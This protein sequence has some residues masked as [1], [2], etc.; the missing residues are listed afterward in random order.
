MRCAIFYI[1]TPI[2]QRRVSDRRPDDHKDYD[3]V[4]PSNGVDIQDTACIRMEIVEAEDLGAALDMAQPR[5]GESVMNT[6]EVAD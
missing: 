3:Y 2:D 5:E 6:H 4:F 1:L